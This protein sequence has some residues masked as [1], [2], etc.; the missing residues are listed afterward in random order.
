MFKSPLQTG[1][2]YG[3]VHTRQSRDLQSPQ[4]FPLGKAE[5]KFGGSSGFATR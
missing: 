4:R 1:Q 3:I 5:G 2:M